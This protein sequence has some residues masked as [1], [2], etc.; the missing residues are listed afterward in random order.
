VKKN[1]V[2]AK[3]QKYADKLAE[4]K[5]NTKKSQATMG[6]GKL[7]T[8]ATIARMKKEIFF[9]QSNPLLEALKERTKKPVAIKGKIGKILDVPIYYNEIKK[10]VTMTRY[11]DPI[12]VE[13]KPEKRIPTR[14]NAKKLKEK[15]NALWTSIARQVA[16]DMV[17]QK[18]II[19]SDR[20]RTCCP[21]GHLSLRFT[22]TVSE[23]AAF[24]AIVE[25]IKRGLL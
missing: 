4:E 20:D 22:E 13:D 2:K 11:A 9:Y 17:N 12:I 24:T 18:Q 6:I 25:M 21:I 23:N 14:F 16:F 10:P 5:R 8:K 1:T 15:H 3:A 7:R 19:N